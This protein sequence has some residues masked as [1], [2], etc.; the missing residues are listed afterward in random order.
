DGWLSGTGIL[1][2]QKAVDLAVY[3]I[4]N[5]KRPAVIV[6]YGARESMT[7]II[8]FA[9]KINAPVLTTFKA[10]G[11]IPDDHPLATGVLGKSGTPVSAYFMN[12]SDLLIVFGASF[13]QH[14]GID[15]S[16]PLIQVDNDRMALAKFHGIDS[17]VW[18]DAALTAE[19]FTEKLS[20]ISFPENRYIEIK[21]RRE[22]W[23]KE[24]EKLAESVNDKGLN[25]VRIF[26]ILSSLLPSDAL[27]SLD[28]G[29][30]TYSFGRYFECRDQ[31]VI[32]SGYLGSIGFAFPAALGAYYAG[33]GRPVVSISGDG[34]FGQYMSEFNTAV[35][36]NINTTHILLNNN[37]LGKISDEQRDEN[38]KIW[39]TELHN[40]D[41]SRFA[42]NCG[43]LGIR[44]SDIEELKPAVEE[45]LAYNGPSL[46]EIVTDPKLS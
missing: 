44:V 1:P 35:L 39:K 21:E 26:S 45:A 5:S 4:A 32:L 22:S 46:V 8:A 24:K 18:G 37:E 31:R 10:K 9:E 25:E 38:L 43:G 6:G 36:Y 28:V 34:G 2:D 20:G 3:R 27:I 16:K 29:N 17:P 11:Q 14:T 7:E 41:F 15:A 13:S 19:R 40:P 42:L 30:N 33:T 12:S 23:R